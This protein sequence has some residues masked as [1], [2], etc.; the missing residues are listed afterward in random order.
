MNAGRMG[1]M[2]L[3]RVPLLAL[4]FVDTECRDL[5]CRGV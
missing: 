3:W 1:L 5:L 4:V 2:S